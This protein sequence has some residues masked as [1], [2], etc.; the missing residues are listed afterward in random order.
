MEVI[1]DTNALS[2]LIKSDKTLIEFLSN[3]SSVTTTT[4]TLGEYQFGILKSNRSA[5]LKEALNRALEPQKILTVDPETSEIYAEIRLHLKSVGKPIPVN[6]LWIAAIA[7]QHDLP[8]VTRDKH[9]DSVIGLNV[10]TW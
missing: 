9:F 1:L 8:L 2:A 7:C 4:I 5:L 6:D 10:L 3:F